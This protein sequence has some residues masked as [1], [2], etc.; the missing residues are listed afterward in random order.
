MEDYDDSYDY[1]DDNANSRPTWHSHSDGY[2][3][4]S[5]TNNNANV[6]CE[7]CG[8]MYTTRSIMLRH[9]NHECGVEKKVFCSIC[10]KRFRR[11]WNLKQHIKKVHQKHSNET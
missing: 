9:R 3:R 10:F 8:K 5:R 2:Y 6:P 4:N 11:Q 1:G 7:K